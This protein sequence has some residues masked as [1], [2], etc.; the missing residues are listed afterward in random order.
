MMIESVSK[1]HGSANMKDEKYSDW[2]KRHH[3]DVDFQ[4]NPG[5]LELKVVFELKNRPSALS[6][7]PHTFAE[8]EPVT[9]PFTHSTYQVRDVNGNKIFEKK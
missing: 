3:V 4:V 2:R 5:L 1:Q 9:E 6:R 7:V 8:E